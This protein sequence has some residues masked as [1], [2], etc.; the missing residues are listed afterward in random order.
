LAQYSKY[1]QHFQ[2]KEQ[3]KKYIHAKKHINDYK[4][5][6]S[7]LEEYIPKKQEE[8][9]EIKQITNATT[10]MEERKEYILQNVQDGKI[11]ITF[12]IKP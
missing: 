12:T 6:A 10:S 5:L 4:N 8:L 1:F 9:E 2:N 11:K 3:I 7:F